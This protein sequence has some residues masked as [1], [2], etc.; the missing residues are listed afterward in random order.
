MEIT[1]LPEGATTEAGLVVAVVILLA[2][3]VIHCL[4]IRG[5]RRRV[6]ELERRTTDDGR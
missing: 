6:E 3:T 5:L 2:T 1:I 4:A